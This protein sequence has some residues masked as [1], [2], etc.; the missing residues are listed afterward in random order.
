MAWG[1]RLLS[2]DT[3]TSAHAV[4]ALRTANLYPTYDVVRDAILRYGIESHSVVDVQNA[5]RVLSDRQ[6]FAEDRTCVEVVAYIHVE[7]AAVSTRLPDEAAKAF[8]EALL[9]SVFVNRA[10]GVAPPQMGSF[11]VAWPAD[12][13]TIGE[14]ALCAR[15][16]LI[17]RK[18]GELYEL[19]PE[20]SV[21]Q[22]LIVVQSPDNLPRPTWGDVCCD[23]RRAIAHSVEEAAAN[24]VA[25]DVASIGVGSDFQASLQRCGLVNQPALLR[26]LY[27][28]AVLAAAGRLAATAGARLHP[29]RESDAADAPQRRREN[30][31]GLWRCMLTKRGA[32]FRIHYWHAASGTV[33]LD[34]VMVES[35]V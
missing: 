16:S 14:L 21:E 1:T 34:S 30:G 13:E 17:G 2:L 29:V 28:L 4:A 35:E 31:D 24:N 12:D 11:D 5:I 10:H 22:E 23:P 32:G 9:G 18:A 25:V 7:P 33:E 3:C 15:L 8:R 6:P 27:R 20:V 19:D 26:R